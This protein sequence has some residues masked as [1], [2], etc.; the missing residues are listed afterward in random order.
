MAKNADISHFTTILGIF[1]A[2]QACQNYKNI[3][4]LKRRF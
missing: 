1:Y 4:M 3:S 2:L